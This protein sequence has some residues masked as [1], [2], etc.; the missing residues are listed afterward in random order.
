MV[1]TVYN[2]VDELVTTITFLATVVLYQMEPGLFTSFIISV[3]LNPPLQMVVPDIGVDG[4]YIFH[5]DHLVCGH[6]G[7]LHSLHQDVV[8]LIGRCSS[9]ID[10]ACIGAVR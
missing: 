10:I 3:Q 4:L 2:S 1:D 6:P 8:H 9:C 5:R 7:A